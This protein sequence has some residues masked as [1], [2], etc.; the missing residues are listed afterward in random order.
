MM[1]KRAPASLGAV[2]GGSRELQT[3]RGQVSP[4]AWLEAVGQRIADRSRPEKLTRGTLWVRVTSSAWAQE[5]SLQSQLIVSRL[6]G[7][8]VPVEELR[9]R[10]GLEV[11]TTTKKATAIPTSRRAALPPSLEQSL[12]KVEDPALKAAIA[13]AAAFS[14]GRRRRPAR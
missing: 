5:L 13:D 14:L 8:G 4:A 3:P 10:V 2:L 9:F 6:Q 12:A 1:A 7:A 11:T